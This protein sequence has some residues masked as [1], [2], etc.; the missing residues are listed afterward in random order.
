YFQKLTLKII[1]PIKTISII[2]FAAIVVVMFKSNY[3]FFIGY[4]HLIFII[5]LIHNAVALLS[6]Y[7][8][9][10]A[11]RCGEAEKRTITIETGIQN[12]GL[13]LALLFNPKIF[14]ED[15]AIGGMAFIAAWWGIWHL[16]AGLSIAGIWSY[17][18][19]KD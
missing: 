8:F 17:R 19:P 7:L 16:I 14:P 2:C 4:I 9:S 15:L 18:K 6:G 13:A 3:D 1:R 11:F 10:S 12:S 5:V